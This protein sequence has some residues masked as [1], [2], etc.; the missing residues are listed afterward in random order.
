[1]EVPSLTVSVAT[2]RRSVSKVSENAPETH[3]EVLRGGIAVLPGMSEKILLESKA[4][5]GGMHGAHETIR[6]GNNQ[7]ALHGW[8]D[9]EILANITNGRLGGLNHNEVSVHYGQDG[10]QVVDLSAVLRK[11]GS[12]ADL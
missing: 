2:G 8:E 4:D 9:Y 10:L 11:R 1:V 3:H 6:I 7:V 5:W 12:S